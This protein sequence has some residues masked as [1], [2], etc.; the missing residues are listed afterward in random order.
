MT[1]RKT[2]D[3]VH[4]PASPAE[5]GRSLCG[6]TTGRTTTRAVSVTCAACKR[7]WNTPTITKEA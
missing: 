4:T 7:L 3:V 2:S 1:N 5:P 6:A